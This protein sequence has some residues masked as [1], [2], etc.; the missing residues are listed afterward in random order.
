MMKRWLPIG[1]FGVCAIAALTAAAGA[2]GGYLVYAGSYTDSPSMSKGIYAWR[3]DP[4][5]GSATSLGL[6]A[7]TVNPA[8]VCA[9]PDGRFLYAVN[10]K[11]AEAAQA[12]TV[13]AYTINKSTGALR[14]LNK[15]SAGGGLPNQVIVDPRGKIAMVTN[16]GSTGNGTA[17]NNSSLAALPIQADGRLGAPFYVDHHTGTALSPRQTTGAKTHG[18]VFT[19]NDR[20]AFVS[21]LGLDRVYIYHVDAAKPAVTPADPPFV[22]M[23]AGSG[24]RRLALS[25][26]EK[27]LYVNHETDSKVSVF[28]INGD[29]LKE[30][31]QISTLPTDFTGR[32]STAEIQMDKAGRFLYVSNRGANSIAVYAVDP[33]KR[34]L[35]LREFVP[36]LGQSPRNITID[37]T[38]HF[39][40]AANQVSNNIAVFRMDPQSG[41]LTPTGQ[42]LH[43]DQPASVFLVKFGTT[44][45][46]G[47]DR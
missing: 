31:Q 18:V 26:D 23:S 13:S 30:I 45:E 10:W 38:G 15:A 20:L 46:T 16:F 1:V 5:S 12:D 47:Q 9:T 34:T 40:F 21:E 32:N 8:Y 28:A 19:K 17:H 37:P 22:T 11:T 24:P 44:S 3:F 33:A 43:M 35:T 36:A 4:S 42:E 41:H 29:T 6:V 39:F 25:P 7:E 2:E 14:F 27:F